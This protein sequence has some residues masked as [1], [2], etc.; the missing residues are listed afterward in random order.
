[1]SCSSNTSP[2]ECQDTPLQRLNS[3]VP[4][5]LAY[6]LPFLYVIPSSA[7]WFQSSLYS[8]A[9]PLL[10]WWAPFDKSEG[11]QINA[12]QGL[13]ESVLVVNKSKGQI[14]SQ[15]GERKRH[16]RTQFLIKGKN[17]VKN[18]DTYVFQTL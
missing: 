10:A 8:H 14:D 17:C 5:A 4:T 13:L 9:C 6:L 7:C 11:L 16:L 15:G 18:V 3:S 2:L 12:L 1:M